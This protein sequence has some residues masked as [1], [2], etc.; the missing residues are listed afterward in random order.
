MTNSHGQ[1]TL[2]QLMGGGKPRAAQLNIGDIFSFVDA[3]R[4]RGLTGIKDGSI[5]ETLVSPA[6]TRFFSND[7]GPPTVRAKSFLTAFAQKEFRKRLR[8]HVIEG[9]DPPSREGLDGLSFPGSPDLQ[10]RYAKTFELL[11]AYLCIEELGALSAGF[12]VTIAGAPQGGDFD[13]VASF[14]DMLLYME[15]KSGEKL[16]REHIERFV[17]RHCF[18]HA[19]LS[20]LFVDYEGI[21]EEIIRSANGIAIYDSY[22]I[23]HIRKLERNSTVFYT[24]EPDVVIVDLH[25]S[26]NVTENIRSVLR[27]YWGYQSLVRRMEY[28]MIN[29]G[30]L[31]YTVTTLVGAQADFHSEC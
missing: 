12:G 8:K 22:V 31:G 7:F 29:P 13:C 5:G 16:K 18:L 10:R 21:N 26:G 11:L 1:L 2:T 20:I 27:Y 19:E 6:A 14:R 3:L 4:Q 24:L 9:S 25:K 30:Q 15:V 28:E 23:N 17:Q